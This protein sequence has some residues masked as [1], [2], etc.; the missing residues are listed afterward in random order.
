MSDGCH[1]HAL[2]SAGGCNPRIYSAG[3]R[4]SI[5]RGQV[6]VG[7]THL[8]GFA[9]ADQAVSVVCVRVPDRPGYRRQHFLM[10][11]VREE[12]VHFGTRPGI[13]RGLA[14]R[15]GDHLRRWWCWRPPSPS[16]VCSRWCSWPTSAS[17]SRL[18]CCW[19]PSS[20]GSCWSQPW[21]TTSARP[22][23]GRRPSRPPPASSSRGPG[24]HRAPDL[25]P[26]P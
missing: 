23:G 1:G 19:T 11:R 8:S 24:G 17:P 18:V 20:S 25:Q 4:G 16:W 21:P 7:F 14:D 5:W 2:R 6:R 22:S 10:T 15:R 9:G 13:V 26:T 12:S 3:V